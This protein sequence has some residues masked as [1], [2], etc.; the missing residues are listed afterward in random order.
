[1]HQN[2]D[3][4]VGIHRGLNNILPT[5][6]CRDG[7]IIGR[8]LATSLLDHLRGLLG[9]RARLA[10]AI[11]RGTEVVDHHLGPFRRHEL[12]DFSANTIATASDHGDF[13]LK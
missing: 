7:V 6:G 1:M 3:L 4:A 5:F 12:T 13:A 8:R 9:S 10:D 11:H 2:V